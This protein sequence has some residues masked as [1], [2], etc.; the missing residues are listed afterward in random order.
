[1][2]RVEEEKRDGDRRG[3]HQE[4]GGWE[5]CRVPGYVGKKVK[6]SEARGH[7]IIRK[8]AFKRHLGK[9]AKKLECRTW[10]TGKRG[11]NRIAGTEELGPGKCLTSANRT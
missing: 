10:T 8:K 4:T 3:D 2:D 5:K 1:V 9:T 11:G 6:N 7:K